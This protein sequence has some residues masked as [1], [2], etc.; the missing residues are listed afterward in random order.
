MEST[1]FQI[2]RGQEGDLFLKE[3]ESF[4]WT[5]MKKTLDLEHIGL[6]AISV[7][8]RILFVLQ[9]PGHESNN[10]IILSYS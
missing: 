1:F 7:I 6:R 3:R 5:L 9:Q 2:W 4:N 10:M 8:M